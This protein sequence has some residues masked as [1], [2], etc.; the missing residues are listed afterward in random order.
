MTDVKK[1]SFFLTRWIWQWLIGNEINKNVWIMNFLTYG[2][3]N[4]EAFNAL[5]YLKFWNWVKR[6][7]TLVE[8]MYSGHRICAWFHKYTNAYLHW[9][10]VLIFF[11]DLES[12]LKYVLMLHKLNIVYSA[13]I[14]ALRLSLKKKL[15]RTIIHIYALLH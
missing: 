11:L 6:K 15:N 2:F 10:N 9:K 3:W 4:K 5:S 12:K 14:E 13:N 1:N 8:P 7:T